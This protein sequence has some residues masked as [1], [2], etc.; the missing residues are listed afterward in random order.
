[1]I[2]AVVDVQE[3][4][5]KS[6]QG[7]LRKLLE[8]GVVDALLVPMTLPAGMVA[9]MLVTD[10]AALDRANPLAPILP[11][12][13]ARAAANLT[14]T[15][16]KEK[17]GVVLRAC[18]IRAL[19]ELVK[20]QQ[21]K[22]DGALIIGIDCLGTYGLTAWQ[23][24]TDKQQVVDGLLAGA[25]SGDL[26]PHDGMEFRTDST[27]CPQALVAPQPLRGLRNLSSEFMRSAA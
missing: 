17:L 18:E 16:H 23:A 27:K 7:L 15:G 4:T 19:V 6:V 8:A 21:A 11:I 3:T 20:F 9:P 22:L 24:A 26:Q 25:P 12:N 2:E 13:A 14:I 10:P 1:M 5:L